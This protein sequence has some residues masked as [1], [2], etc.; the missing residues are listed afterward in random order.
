VSSCQF[1]YLRE[2]IPLNCTDIS[3]K[4]IATFLSK[5][6]LGA[7]NDPHLTPF[8]GTSISSSEPDSIDLLEVSDRPMETKK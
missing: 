2:K 5:R 3:N 6:L 7:A 1:F 4:S 8:L